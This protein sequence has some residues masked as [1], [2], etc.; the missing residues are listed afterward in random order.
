MFRSKTN[1]YSQVEH[2]SMLRNVDVEVCPVGFLAIYLFSR[3]NLFHE[4]FPDLTDASKWYPTKLIYGK[5]PNE[6]LNATSHSNCV[7][8]MIAKVKLSCTK[9]THIGRSSTV[10]KLDSLGCSEDQMMRAGR[11]KRER[12]YTNYCLNLPIEAMKLIAGANKEYGNYNINRAVLEP[13]ESLVNQ[14]FP[15]L[16]DYKNEDISQDTTAVKFKELL[17]WLSKVFIQDTAIFIHLDEFKGQKLFGLPIFSSQEFI[18]C[19]KMAIRSELAYNNRPLQ[20]SVF[21]S[22]AA[23]EIV[24]L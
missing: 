22:Q 20:E 17:L 3:F 18:Q 24:V 6:I 2:A 23:P 5:S 9:I 8:K 16:V 12:M 7:Q 10:K 1:Q 14:V 15:Q 19:S 4:S 21:I 11:W 13:P